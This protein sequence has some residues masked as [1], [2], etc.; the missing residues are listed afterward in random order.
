MSSRPP[1][2][3]QGHNCVQPVWP[4]PHLSLIV[5][6]DEPQYLSRLLHKASSACAR[7][8]SSRV[9]RCKGPQAHAV[10]DHVYGCISLTSF[11][12]KSLSR[13]PAVSSRLDPTTFNQTSCHEVTVM[14][15]A[16]AVMQHAGQLRTEVH[17]ATCAWRSSGAAPMVSK[18]SLN[19]S[20][21]GSRC[22]LCPNGP[23]HSPF[24]LNA[25]CGHAR[26]IT[27]RPQ[28]LT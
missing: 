12:I 2:H 23:V 11:R 6:Q 4:A 19:S 21:M 5:V 27:L 28:R 25:S 20:N 16:R 7:C 1:S 15:D 18:V 26:S 10:V 24:T 22:A 3:T 9:P 14:L 13:G 8:K 17:D